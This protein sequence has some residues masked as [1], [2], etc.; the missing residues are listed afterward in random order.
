M[1]NFQRA[2]DFFVIA[3]WFLTL[4]SVRVLVNAR[5]V[6]LS[7]STRLRRGLL[8]GGKTKKK[9]L[10]LFSRRRFENRSPLVSL[11]RR[12]RIEVYLYDS[13]RAHKI[14]MYAVSLSLSSA[15]VC[16]E[17]WVRSVREKWVKIFAFFARDG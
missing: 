4:S 15:R 13:Q 7:L 8:G 3:G 10:S 14:Y 12:G 6:S 2:R 1:Q 16:V 11:F 5:V 17:R 9:S